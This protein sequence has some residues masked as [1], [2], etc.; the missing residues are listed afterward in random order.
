MHSITSDDMFQT[1]YKIY[2]K[3]GNNTHWLLKYVLHWNVRFNN[4]FGYG[5][6]E[7]KLRPIDKIIIRRTEKTIKL[8][9]KTLKKVRQVIA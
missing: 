4:L 1:S 7:K 5:R 9:K 6:I 2:N 3:I 8:L